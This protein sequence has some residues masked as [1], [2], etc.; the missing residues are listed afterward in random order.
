MV[1]LDKTTQHIIRSMRKAFTMIELIFAI[2]II[3]VVVLT[4][5]MMIQVNNKALEGNSAQEAIFLVSSVLS[6]ITTRLWDENSTQSVGG[7]FT[8]SKMLDVAGGDPVYNRVDVN[9]T[10][11]IGG[12]QEDM[13]RQFFSTPAGPSATDNTTINFDEVAL[14][15]AFGLKNAYDLTI[16]RIYVSDTP[17]TLGLNTFEFSTT[18]ALGAS[19]NI[20]MLD[21]SVKAM[22]DGNLTEITRLRAYTC[23]IGEIDFAKRSF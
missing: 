21:L 9:S 3:S 20:K 14:G 4:I 17:D 22:I 8:L 6:G 7:T 11:R 12:I 1:I 2:V 23:N 5:P 13:H 15:Q 18:P 10:I 19:T 16:S